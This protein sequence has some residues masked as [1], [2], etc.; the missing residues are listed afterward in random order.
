MLAHLFNE[1]LTVYRASYAADGVGGRTKTMAAHGTIR[2]Q[3]EQP[4]TQERM[5]A[6]QMGATLTH[7]VHTAYD[8]D[9]IRDDELDNGGARRLRVKSVVSNSRRTYKR[10][11][12]ELI[13]DGS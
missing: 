8:A 6:G 12:C 1:S 3:V 5:V 9:V 10:L 2:A 13:Q 7:V 11:E 4:S